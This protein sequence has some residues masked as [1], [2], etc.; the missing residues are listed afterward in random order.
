MKP[1]EVDS[2]KLDHG[3]NMMYAG[4]LLPGAF[5]GGGRASS[6]FLAS[7]VGLNTISKNCLGIFEVHDTIAIVGTRGT[8]ILVRLEALAI[9]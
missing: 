5:R 6:N 2:E 9:I 3:R 8:L 7:S 1:S 4:A